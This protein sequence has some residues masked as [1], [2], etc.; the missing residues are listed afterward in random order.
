MAP[1]GRILAQVIVP[2]IATLARAIPAA[3][4]Q[5][6]Q[7]AKKG[8]VDAAQSTTAFARKVMSKEEAMMVL[9]VS[10]EEVTAEIVEKVSSCCCCCCCRCCWNGWMVLAIFYCCGF[11]ILTT[12]VTLTHSNYSALFINAN[13]QTNKQNVAINETVSLQQYQRY[14]AANSMERGGSFYLQSKVY[15]AKEMLDTFVK[16]QQQS[17]QRKGEEPT[18]KQ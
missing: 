14:F 9:N 6:V 16:E 15:R 11:R 7:N 8:G 10:S 13:K 18:M 3:Y 12:M 5:A 2:I 17:E 1:L 4:A